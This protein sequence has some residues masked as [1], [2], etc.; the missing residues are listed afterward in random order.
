MDIGNIA[1]Q[2]QQRMDLSAQQAAAGTFAGRQVTVSDPV[3]LAMDAA[4]EAG[5]AMSER[6]EKRLEERKMKPRGPDT[7]RVEQVLKY[8]ELMDKQGKKPTLESFLSVLARKNAL[9][10]RDAVDE[11]R[12]FF[13]D[14]ADAYAAL[15]YAKE[16]LGDRFGH[17]VFAEAMDQLEDIA[18]KSLGKALAAG[19]AAV[20]HAAL[21]D[22]DQLK[23]LY[24]NTL[25]DLG[26]P[27]DIY[28]RII[29][30]YGEKGF[31]DALAFLTRSLGNEMAATTVNTDRVELETIAGDLGTVQLLHGLNAQCKALNAR[32]EKNHGRSELTGTEL[33]REVLKLRDAHFVGPFDIESIADRAGVH[34]IEERILFFQDFIATARDFPENLF[35]DSGV[36]LNIIDAI[37]TAIDDA[38]SVED[39]MYES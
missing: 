6:E 9:F 18:G 2:Y 37:Q 31:E 19:A 30:D 38:V 7:Y 11:A 15:Q 3:S 32:I 23:N 36:R 12:R 29:N 1:Q 17:D 25:G 16:N 39:E 4:E 13:G 21:G 24:V 27:V 26:S 28:E 33:V 35:P 5:F 14:N 10:P 20:D 22:G 8:T 34:D